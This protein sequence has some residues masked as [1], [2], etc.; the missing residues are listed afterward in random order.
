MKKY[1]LLL[2]VERIFQLAAHTQSRLH[3]FIFQACRI[4]DI[5]LIVDEPLVNISLTNVL[6]RI[7]RLKKLC[8]NLVVYSL[9]YSKNDK[10]MDF[11][12]ILAIN[13][14]FLLYLFQRCLSKM[15]FPLYLVHVRC[16]VP[17]Y[18]QNLLDILINSL[19]I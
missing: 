12:D 1:N 5:L 13:L 11:A 9:H 14:S 2:S 6:Y 15:Q 4:F 19:F 18:C 7:L 10:S 3:D 16:L 17:S 8:L